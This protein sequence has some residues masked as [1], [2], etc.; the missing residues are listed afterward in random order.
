MKFS[1]I[2]PALN[3]AKIIE[4]TVKR[5][6]QQT[7]K[8]SDYEIVVVDNRSTD[9][10]AQ[11]ARAAGADIVISEKLQGTNFARQRGVEV[12]HGEIV[13]F[14]DADCVP[15]ATWL[16]RIEYNLRKHN[17]AGV[18]GPYDYGFTGLNRIVSTLITDWF[19]PYMADILYLLFGRKA[20]VMIG[21]NF[22]A[23][24]SAINKIGGLPPLSFWGDD[25][26][27]AMLLS[28]HVGKVVFDPELTVKSSPRRFD[29]EGLFRLQAKYTRAYFKIYFS[30]DYE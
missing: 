1:I 28:R 2:I 6:L 24:R 27:T 22:A 12:S 5:L 20:G 23:W 14:L 18:S 9:G 25:A 29:K 26:A 11:L 17:V 13:A 3:E 21:G 8:R 10:T 19:M 7:V 30:K 16:E 15:A 4:R